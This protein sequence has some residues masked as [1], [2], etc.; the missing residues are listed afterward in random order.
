MNSENLTEYI[1][2]IIFGIWIINFFID[3]LFGID[4]VQAILNKIFKKDE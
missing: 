1:L 4:L 3:I 2:G